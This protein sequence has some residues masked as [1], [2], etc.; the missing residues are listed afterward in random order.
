[1]SDTNDEY[2]YAERDKERY[3][4]AEDGTDEAGNERDDEVGGATVLIEACRER[5]KSYCGYFERHT[6]FRRI[7]R[8][9]MY[10][11]GHFYGRDYNYSFRDLRQ[12][13]SQGE[14]VGANINHF[15]NLIQHIL[16][17]ITQHKILIETQAVNVDRESIEQARLGDSVLESYVQKDRIDRFMKRALEHSMIL[18]QG[19]VYTTWD[20]G[21][22]ELLGEPEIDQETGEQ[23]GEATFEGD[24]EICN[25]SAFDVANDPCVIEWDKNEWFIIRTWE[26]KFNL[27]ARF[28][29]LAHEI[30]EVD[31]HQDGYE[32]LFFHFDPTDRAGSITDLVPVFTLI[33]K[34][35]P[36]LPEGKKFSYVGDVPL[37]PV[38]NPYPWKGLTLR[39]I[40]A[41]ESIM[42]GLGYS[43]ALDL[44]GPQE[45][46]N[47][48][49]SAISTN[50]KTFGVQSIWMQHG[51]KPNVSEIGDGLRLIQSRMKPEELSLL[52]TKPEVFQFRQEIGKDMENISGISGTVRGA[53]EAN[54]KSGTAM[55][56]VDAKGVQFS[57]PLAENY[58]Q[59]WEDV[60]ADILYLVDVNMVDEHKRM[61]A[62][63]GK[64]GRPS[65]Y[66]LEKGGL[67]KVDRVTVHA[68]SALARTQSGRL[69]L[70]NLYIKAGLIRIGE[71][72]I[73]VIDSGRLDPLLEAERAQI[74]L[75]R[76]EN[77]KMM[78]QEFNMI[79]AMAT[80]NH[81]LHIREHQAILNS[82]ELRMNVPQ[83]G[84]VMAH[85]MEHI[86]QISDPNVQMIQM[87]LGFDP[88]MPM[89][90]PPPG[91]PEDDPN[92]PDGA[93]LEGAKQPKPPEPPT[94][95]SQ[96]GP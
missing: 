8:N 18:L 25:P 14:Q 78:A 89:G 44:Q 83:A 60:G 64:H 37:D 96:E 63:K 75:V 68:G 11:H 38:N 32:G 5:F 45:I 61:F 95:P 54:V 55:A 91:G 56:L 2:Q 74:D 51:D 86:G 10:Y 62:V 15:R 23:T 20:Y 28:P 87:I 49:T 12:L 67:S 65:Q 1:M 35:T 42:D 33:H 36:A 27:A 82:V 53:P 85:I 22:G 71:E 7:V 39:R 43:A 92:T 73:N 70:A 26:N 58:H 72:L 79:A 93:Q 40:V 57:A 76:D 21:R 30:I 34:P 90:P 31:Y 46:Y 13:G 16:S 47:G 94:S 19:F 24:I 6:T 88:G 66:I 77:E 80:D 41:S 48:E 52:A 29:D 9:Y 59:L 84:Q 17:I 4:A 3:W 69:E 81:R 50:H